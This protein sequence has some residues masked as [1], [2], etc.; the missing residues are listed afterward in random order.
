MGWVT[1]TWRG[2]RGGSK[3]M[4]TWC[5]SAAPCAWLGLQSHAGGC[6]PHPSAPPFW[7]VPVHQDAGR[8]PPSTRSGA[9]RGA[10]CPQHSSSVSFASGV[11][12]TL[13]LSRGTLCFVTPNLNLGPQNLSSQFVLHHGG[14]S[15]GLSCLLRGKR[16]NLGPQQ[17]PEL[18]PVLPV[19][20][21]TKSPA[22]GASKDIRQHSG[23]ECADARALVHGI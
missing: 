12:E 19:T 20:A 15:T 18:P 23:T 16:L 5:I 22:D 2:P 21:S 9:R 13:A 8:P 4:G 10:R 11:P 14:V 1:C 6:N 7:E 3:A 17:A